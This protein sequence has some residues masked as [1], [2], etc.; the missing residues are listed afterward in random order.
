MN[1]NVCIDA[2]DVSLADTFVA[3]LRAEIE[4]QSEGKSSNHGDEIMDA[5]EIQL[6]ETLMNHSLSRLQSREIEGRGPNGVL[7]EGT[8]HLVNTPMIHRALLAGPKTP[9][10][11]SVVPSHLMDATPMK[12]E[13]REGLGVGGDD[14]LYDPNGI[15]DVIRFTDVEETD[16][17]ANGGEEKKDTDNQ[18]SPWDADDD[19]FSGEGSIKDDSFTS[20]TSSLKDGVGD[21]MDEVGVVVSPKPRPSLVRRIKAEDEELEASLAAARVPEWDGLDEWF[22][23]AMKSNDIVRSMKEANE[24]LR[25]DVDHM[26]A[27]IQVC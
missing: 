20:K 3:T 26:T 17:N 19:D 6:R 21:E 2:H 5:S 7:Y 8:S 23:R 1:M 12:N 16:G 15:A 24:T 14:M 13:S 10:D 4:N 22:R 25:E 27:K 11:V 9:I 18:A